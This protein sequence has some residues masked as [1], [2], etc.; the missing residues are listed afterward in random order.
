MADY[1]YQC[2]EGHYIETNRPL[3]ECLAMHKGSPCKG[4]L[5]TKGKREKA[6]AK[7]ESTGGGPLNSDELVLADALGVTK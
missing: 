1:R 4:T 2:S 3:T 5:S 6:A 7:V